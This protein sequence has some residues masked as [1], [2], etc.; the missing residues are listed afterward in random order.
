MKVP[1]HSVHWKHC[2][3]A[4]PTRYPS[5]NL[6][7]RVTA[8]QDITAIEQ[9]DGLTSTRLR[10]ERGE[11]NFLPPGER[12]RGPG[13]QY[14]MASFSYSLFNRSRF[15]DGSYGVYYGSN[16]LRTAVAETKFH[17]EQFMRATREGTMMLPMRVVVAS[18]KGQ[19]H[20]I[21]KIKRKHP[22]L[23]SR[24]NYTQSQAFG[25]D[26]WNQGSEGI[27]YKSVRHPKGECVAV[28][29]PSILSHCREER[30]LLYEWNGRKITKIYELQEFLK[31]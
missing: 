19:L 24:T 23:Y 30:A 10:L 5:E 4:I 21:R 6:L 11:F 3:R 26:L 16:S 9:L 8:P 2:W 12:V 13:S 29:I 20:D 14:I 22:K 18:L 15:S 31:M 17:R 27:V 28:F 25:R 1:V 7:D